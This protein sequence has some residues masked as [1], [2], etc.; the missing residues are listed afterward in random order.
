MTG[1]GRSHGSI[2]VVNAM[3]CGIGATIGV[4]LETVARFT[5]TGGERTVNIMNDASE[6]TQMA[7][8]CVREAYRAAGAEEP[9]GWTLETDSQIPVSRGLKS[10]SCACNAI[11]RAVFDEIGFEMDQVDLIR[12]GV[13]CAREAK[14][15]V[16]GSFDD[17]CGCGLGGLVVTDNRADE[18]IGQRDV[19]DLDVVI[20]VPEFKIRKTGL[21]LEKLRALAPEME[22]VIQMAMTDPFK[23]MTLNGRLISEASEVDNSVAEKA[24]AL[25]ALGAGMSGSGPAV[26]IVVPSGEGAAFAER[27][28]LKPSETILTKTRC[29]Q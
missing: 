28:G 29:G 15:T 14:V 18:V 9:A 26:A 8:I 27:M 16:T 24:M 12:L 3:P 23:A 25:G 20:H 7:R 22:Q 1:T 10:S 11:I 6:N 5:V 19:E 17:A 13:G 2:T 4:A 21:P